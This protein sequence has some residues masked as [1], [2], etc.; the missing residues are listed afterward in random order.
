MRQAV[1]LVLPGTLNKFNLKV[2]MPHLS[3][4]SD[5]LDV[6]R[7][8]YKD[9]DIRALRQSVSV[10]M[11]V[12]V[13]AATHPSG[14]GFGI[15]L[16]DLQEDPD[17]YSIA[18][19][20]IRLLAPTVNGSGTK[21]KVLLDNTLIDEVDV[22]NLLSNSTTLT[23]FR[24]WRQ[25]DGY[26]AMYLIDGTLRATITI[27]D[28][29]LGPN[30]RFR[31]GVS[32]IGNCS[33]NLYTLVYSNKDA[34]AKTIAL[35]GSGT[36]TI[37]AGQ[38]AIV[39]QGRGGAGTVTV[40]DLGQVT[41]PAVSKTIFNDILP[42][43][44][45]V[46]EIPLLE[47]GFI[48]G[49]ILA[50][51]TNALQQYGENLIYVNPRPSGTALID[52]LLTIDNFET[53]VTV[54]K[55]LSPE[56]ICYHDGYFYFKHSLYTAANGTTLSGE[57]FTR[58]YNKVYRTTNFETIETVKTYTSKV[59]VLQILQNNNG[60][61]VL[62]I[63]TEG[64]GSTRDRS[65]LDLN[66]M[67]WS[68][69]QHPGTPVLDSDVLPSGNI[70]VYANK[71]YSSYGGQLLVS[72]NLLSWTIKPGM[73]PIFINALDL[74][75]G[76]GLIC[77]RS[78]SN[79][80][81]YSSDDG[82]TINTYVPPTTI[83]KLL[84]SA[85][86]FTLFSQSG[87]T[88]TCKTF[89]TVTAHPEH[90]AGISFLKTS[91]DLFTANE[92]LIGVKRLS[93]YYGSN[94]GIVVYVG[95]DIDNMVPLELNTYFAAY[96]YFA[97]NNKTLV[98]EAN[99]VCKLKKQG[100][101]ETIVAYVL[102][103]EFGIKTT[104]VGLLGQTVSANI[105]GVNQSFPQSKT[106]YLPTIGKISKNVLITDTPE[107]N[108]TAPIE[109]LLRATYLDVPSVSDGIGK[110]I[111]Y[112]C[113]GFHKTEIR[114]DGNGGTYET[115]VVK[116]SIDCGYNADTL[117]T[118][119]LS[120]NGTIVIPE[121]T[122]SITLSGRGSS[123]VDKTLAIAASPISLNFDIINSPVKNIKQVVSGGGRVLVLADTPKR[124][125]EY[126]GDTNNKII[127]NRKKEAQSVWV[128]D[129]LSNLVKLDTPVGFKAHSAEY[130]PGAN[131]FIINTSNKRYLNSSASNV[132]AD[133]VEYGIPYNSDSTE[134]A[135]G[136]ELRVFN[137]NRNYY[138]ED[139]I[140]FTENR[141]LNRLTSIYPRS[142]YDETNTDFGKRQNTGIYFM[143]LIT[144]VYSGNTSGTPYRGGFVYKDGLF[145]TIPGLDYNAQS[146][147][148]D[149]PGEEENQ[150]F[151]ATYLSEVYA[152][153]PKNIIVDFAVNS[154]E[155][156]FGIV[157]PRYSFHYTDDLSVFKGLE[158]RPVIRVDSGTGESYKS[159]E[160]F[161]SRFTIQATTTCTDDVYIV[162]D[163]GEL[164]YN[165]DCKDPDGWVKFNLDRRLK[166]DIS[167]PFSHY[168]TT[169]YQSSIQGIPYSK[170]I[171]AGEPYVAKLLEYGKTAFVTIGDKLK[172][173]PGN[174]YSTAPASEFNEVIT[175]DPGKETVIVYNCPEG[176]SVSIQYMAVNDG[177]PVAG[178]L[179]NTVCD[180]FNKNGVYANGV[181]GTY[182]NLIEANSLDCGYVVPVIKASIAFSN[183]ADIVEDEIKILKYSLN[184]PLDVNIGLTV[185][186]V[187]NAAANASDIGDLESKING[188]V[189]PITSGTEIT[190]PTGTVEFDISFKAL[191]DEVSEPI[192]GFTL[193][194]TPTTNSSRVLTT[195]IDTVVSIT[196]V[197]MLLEPSNLSYD[198]S[199]Y[200]KRRPT[201]TYSSNYDVIRGTVNKYGIIKTEIGRSSGKY[202]IPLTGINLKTMIVGFGN[203]S[204]SLDGGTTTYTYPGMDINSW[205][206][207]EGGYYHN[208]VFTPV[209]FTWDFE[210]CG[211]LLNLDDKTADLYINGVS[212]NLNITGIDSGDIYLCVGIVDSTLTRSFYLD[213]VAFTQSS[214]IPP[215]GYY[216]GFGVKVRSDV[217]TPVTPPA[218]NILVPDTPSSLLLG[219]T[220]G[221]VYLNAKNIAR[222]VFSA[223]ENVWVIEFDTPLE[224]VFRFGICTSAHPTSVADE[225]DTNTIQL[226]NNSFSYGVEIDGTNC[227]A[228]H[229]GVSKP[230][231]SSVNSRIMSLI[232]DMA[233]KCMY[234]SVDGWSLELIY[235]G[236][237]PAS[238]H[239]AMSTVVT[240]ADGGITTYINTG[241]LANNATNNG[242]ATDY[243][244]QGF[245]AIIGNPPLDKLKTT[246]CDSTTHMGTY[247]DGAG[248][249]SDRVIQ[250][251]SVICGYTLPSNIT[252]GWDN[253]K[254]SAGTAY[255]A[256]GDMIYNL[257][258]GL[259]SA[260]SYSSGKHYFEVLCD[261]QTL[262][263]GVCQDGFAFDNGNAPG[264]EAYSIGFDTSQAILSQDWSQVDSTL[265]PD[266]DDYWLNKTVGILI[267]LDENTMS[268]KY[269]DGTIKA[270][271][272]FVPL[273][274][275]LFVCVF[276]QDYSGMGVEGKN[277]RVNLGQTAFANGLPAGYTAWFTP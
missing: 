53:I 229:N 196:S 46:E 182:T 77:I 155:E 255:S 257:Q 90:T 160:H 149:V 276:A 80:I 74:V 76:N 35:Q 178:T 96:S 25:V 130:L 103:T 10:Q 226:G 114:A 4:N 194:L 262:Y 195:N 70:K 105:D 223:S 200:D 6:S 256:N 22:P 85:G 5:S 161:R 158:L 21:F 84:Y 146:G 270:V 71:F 47:M 201:G 31:A 181:G 185:N 67:S 88:Y 119:T 68:D 197:D 188:V 277:I 164:Y 58:D 222:T 30:V 109:T 171:P 252:S 219:E 95:P 150:L 239:A 204:M 243:M 251:Y 65:I 140:T 48:Y 152:S 205:G 246:Y 44:Y 254:A 59:Q 15:T 203:S 175:V 187:F 190:V 176:S 198:G 227:L 78:A 157:G 172:I 63:A 237:I 38:Q 98:I 108:Y 81:D 79:R 221:V 113:N 1:H 92:R 207:K 210:E 111:S 272:G 115:I 145:R 41:A 29:V 202:Y 51:E 23:E 45:F 93:G 2:H 220:A 126:F 275:P 33:V 7:F 128:G 242:L 191:F 135:C 82:N 217:Y 28:T 20:K 214:Y 273:T 193:N 216:K 34:V 87:Q 101:R 235:E 247:H 40:F 268:V 253:T 138:S 233:N 62:Y 177:S 167:N 104:S 94:A 102:D 269:H 106:N 3:F 142:L 123:M 225:I 153:A 17:I 14:C 206:I 228:Y 60:D 129:N 83:D 168:A 148:Y 11:H 116:N 159:L 73:F 72:E 56:K 154:Q 136:N 249:F 189:T 151:T 179:L 173:I 110:F 127:R 137:G 66:T 69:T 174:R 199:D 186:T 37:P 86:V 107:I 8:D 265:F 180:G 248:G 147:Y 192:E 267:N 100:K 241:R 118:I 156:V 240:E 134:Y 144:D 139:G 49:N 27:P 184:Q 234:V 99:P 143:G 231:T 36:F 244:F 271:S 165:T 120:G 208:G 166:N 75:F 218:S 261:K 131:V 50:Q 132:F 263:V 264:N 54:P 211:L 64:S 238:Y 42:P 245:G 224:G 26:K 258:G 170:K 266:V 9:E 19:K 16:F 212:Q 124:T 89:D 141:F 169:Y 163:I 39:L 230:L 232:L 122:S 213:T 97:Y 125:I 57:S 121:G 13:D 18:G 91:Y 162:T 236:I 133:W 209:A 250:E 260:Q 55:T 183:T 112:S 117:K 24:F 43:S 12:M 32:L 274:N 215:L 259:V 52:G 61:K